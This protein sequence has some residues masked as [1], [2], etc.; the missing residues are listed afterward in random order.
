M[1]Q[2]PTWRYWIV[3]IVL[4]AATLLALPN[5][6]TYDDSLEISRADR[7]AMDAAAQERITGIL[8]SVSIAPNP[9]ITGALGA[10]ILAARQLKIDRALSKL[11]K[12]DWPKTLDELERRRQKQ[13]G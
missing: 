3:G 1:Y 13:V 9:Q 8:K 5:I 6:Y 11:L 7:A 4:V 12:S 10:A 2:F